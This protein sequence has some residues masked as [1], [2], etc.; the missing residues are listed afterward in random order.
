MSL[1]WEEW[2]GKP[3]DDRSLQD[4]EPFRRFGW[5]L[6][7]EQETLVN[8]TIRVAVRQEEQNLA[9]GLRLC[10]APGGGRAALADGVAGT[11]SGSSRPG[12][13]AG[14]VALAAAGSL[15]RRDSG[16]A[17]SSG[18]RSTAAAKE[19]LLQMFKV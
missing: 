2:Q 6:S 15:L 17:E 9:L 16:F 7:H 14:A 19:Q 8:E 5:L 3:V 1:L 10:D 18:G 11:S 12:A 4:L 13:E